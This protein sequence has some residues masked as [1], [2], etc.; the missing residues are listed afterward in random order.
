MN[1]W[2][3]QCSSLSWCYLDEHAP[4]M[5]I[6]L[7]PVSSHCTGRPANPNT[8]DLCGSG[9][10]PT[11]NDPRLRTYNRHVPAGSDADVYKH[12]P[13][14]APGSAP[15]LDPCGM[16]SGGPPGEPTWPLAGS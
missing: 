5:R 2:P 10:Q 12:N 11:L 6:S 9:M 8:K 16:A 15:V 13:W 1:S 7:S 14:R 3:L 4:T